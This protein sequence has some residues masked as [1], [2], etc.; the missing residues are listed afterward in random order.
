MEYV[1]ND[2]APDRLRGRP[3]FGFIAEDVSDALPQL[4]VRDETGAPVGVNYTHVVPIAV[5]AIR[6]L[7]AECDD[8][9][10]RNAALES[11]LAALTND[12]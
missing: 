12:H 10:A 3:D 11:R 2:A 7:K 9:R 1:W 8:L 5:E 4:A 6:E